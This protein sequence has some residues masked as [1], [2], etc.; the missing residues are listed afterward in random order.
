MLSSFLSRLYPGL[1]SAV[2]FLIILWLTLIPHPLPADTP[3]LFP[4]ADKVVHALM[5][6]GLVLTLVIDRELW[7]QR[8]YEDKGRLPRRCRY[9]PWGFALIAI[10]IGGAIELLQGWM[11]LGRGCDVYDFVADIAGALIFALLAPRI[12][13]LLLTPP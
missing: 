12:A 9:E 3:E 7:C 6:G 4:G 1:L 5:F 2:T 11:G 10:V 8:S 13:M